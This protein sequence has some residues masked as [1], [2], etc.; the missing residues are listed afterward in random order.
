LTQS[1]YQIYTLCH[2]FLTT[3]CH[4]CFTF[5]STLYQVLTKSRCTVDTKLRPS[6]HKVNTL[7]FQLCIIQGMC[8]EELYQV[9]WKVEHKVGTLYQPL[10]EF[11]WNKALKSMKLCIISHT[12]FKY[13]VVTKLIQ[14]KY[15][16]DTKFK[17]CVPTLH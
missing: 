3:S 2:K 17:H 6:W 1:Y 12:K 15:Q 8:C 11:V 7:S 10:N 5:V 16:V 13:K 14:S 9:L 4:L